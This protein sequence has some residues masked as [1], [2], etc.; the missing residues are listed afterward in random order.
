LSEEDWSVAYQSASGPGETWLGPSV[1][2]TV[3]LLAERGES[4]VVL[5][6]CGFVAEQVEILYDLDIVSKQK[7]ADLGVQ[8]VR[9][10]LLGDGPA[11]VD[12][13]ALLVERWQA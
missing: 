9:T 3:R 10:Q 5:C 6:P 7:A 4:R 12:T 11:V 2:E 8:M 1:D 13:M